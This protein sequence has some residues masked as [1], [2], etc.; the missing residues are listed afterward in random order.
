MHL[1]VAGM[2]MQ[3]DAAAEDVHRWMSAEGRPQAGGTG[4]PENTPGTKPMAGL[5]E[6]M[7]RGNSCF[8]HMY[9]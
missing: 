2:R 8:M 4:V 5:C 1:T 7:Y 6:H 9:K 3:E